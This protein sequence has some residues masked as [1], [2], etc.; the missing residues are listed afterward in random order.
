M[1]LKKHE[2]NNIMGDWKAKIGKERENQFVG[3]YGLGERNN[4]GERLD[5]SP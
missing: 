2:T 3:A 5:A 4:R 1:Q